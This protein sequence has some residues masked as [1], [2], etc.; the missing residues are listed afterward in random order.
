M[1]PN[2]P[3]QRVDA[4]NDA[5]GRGLGMA[6][7]RHHADVRVD[8]DG[9]QPAAFWRFIAARVRAARP[10]ISSPKKSVGQFRMLP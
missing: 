1:A 10:P 2:D 5:I 9:G 6:F 8:D 3:L 7:V 4:G